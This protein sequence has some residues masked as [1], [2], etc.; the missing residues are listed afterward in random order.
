LKKTRVPFSVYATALLLQRG[1]T[2]SSACS[3]TCTQNINVHH[4]YCM[5]HARD[6]DDVY[7]RPTPPCRKM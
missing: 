2:Q 5:A 6:D 7:C 1:R 4:V 3:C